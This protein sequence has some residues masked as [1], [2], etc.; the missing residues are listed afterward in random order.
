MVPQIQALPRETL[1]AYLRNPALAEYEFVL[2]KIIRR[3]P[4]TRN[5]EAEQLLAM[6]GESLSA[7]RQIFSQLDNADLN[8][9]HLP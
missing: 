7:P 4:H 3:I 9:G 8:F 5:A 2:K 6:A 1:D